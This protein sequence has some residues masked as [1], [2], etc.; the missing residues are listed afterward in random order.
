[1][2]AVRVVIPVVMISHIIWV[3]VGALY[4]FAQSQQVALAIVPEVVV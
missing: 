2:T 4:A 3:A 1:M